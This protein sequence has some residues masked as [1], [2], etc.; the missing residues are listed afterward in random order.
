MSARTAYAWGATTTGLMMNGMVALSYGLLFLGLAFLLLGL[1]S[2]I[3]AG[4][5]L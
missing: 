5:Q 2:G 4:T 1:S 3:Y